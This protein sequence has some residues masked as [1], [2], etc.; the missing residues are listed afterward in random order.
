NSLRTADEADRAVDHVREN[1][2]RDRLVVARKVAVGA[3]HLPLEDLV[4][5]RGGEAVEHR[6]A[7]RF[8]LPFCCNA[9]CWSQ[10]SL[11]AAR[12]VTS[13]VSRRLVFAQALKA[14]MAEAGRARPF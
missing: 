14:W 7:L 3:A 12:N 1:V 9:F 5:A 6:I 8:R 10:F 11:L 4:A 13:H 2:R